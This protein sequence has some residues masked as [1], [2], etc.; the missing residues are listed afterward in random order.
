MRL[1]PHDITVTR[2]G[3]AEPFE[4][5][6]EGHGRYR[7]VKIGSADTTMDGEHTYVIR[8]SVDGVLS[9][10]GEGLAVLLEPDPG[11]LADADRAV[12]ADRP[13]ARRGQRRPVRRRGGASTGCVVRGVGDRTLVTTGGSRR[14]PR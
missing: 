7:N 12:H 4:V 5:L 11:R 14:T 2:D 13:P 8:Y 1:V 9:S 10:R 6:R 3:R